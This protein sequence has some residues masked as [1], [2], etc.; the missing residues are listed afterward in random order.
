MKAAFLLIS[1]CAITTSVR[2]AEGS[3]HQL[4]EWSLG[5][6]LFGDPQTP[7]TMKNKVV[8]I[9][10]WGVQC[11]PCIALLPH[12]ADLDRKNR[13]KGL[14]VIGAESQ[15]HTK[16]Q[17]EPLVKKNKIEYTITSGAS[18]PIK[19]S[20]IPRAFV[21]DVNGALIFDGNPGDGKFEK[22]VKAALR[23]VKKSSAE[24]EKPSDLIETSTWS[25]TDGIQIKAAVKS[26]SETEVVFEMFGGKMI[27]YPM[28][29]LTQESQDR[30]KQAI[31]AQ[32]APAE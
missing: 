19:L 11:P 3:A 25:N 12:M 2:G 23:E 10:H 6:V 28:A 5:S 14:V 16:E 26:A 1:L 27:K 7:A 15:M 30:I 22:T 13:Q 17:I 8:I 32:P 4:S 29:K 9:E 24:L 18:G 20:A 21:F 31:V